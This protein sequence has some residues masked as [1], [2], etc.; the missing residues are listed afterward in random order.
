MRTSEP[1]L[2]L[3]DALLLVEHERVMETHTREPVV[4]VSRYAP[5]L[6]DWLGPLESNKPAQQEMSVELAAVGSAAPPHIDDVAESTQA[7]LAGA[8]QPDVLQIVM[9]FDGDEDG[10]YVGRKALNEAFT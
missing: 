6:F 1:A 8:L 4:V 10:K 2:Q 9:S 7:S 3:K 5:L